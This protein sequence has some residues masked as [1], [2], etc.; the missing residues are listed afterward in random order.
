MTTETRRR[1]GERLVSNR[2]Y[3]TLSVDLEEAR[4]K[5]MDD[6]RGAAPPKPPF[7]RAGG[8]LETLAAH[9][10]ADSASPARTDAPSLCRPPDRNGW[11]TSRRPADRSGAAWSKPVARSVRLPGGMP[12]RLGPIIQHHAA[13]DACWGLSAAASVILAPTA[14]AEVCPASLGF[15]DSPRPTP[16]FAR[17]SRAVRRTSL[18]FCVRSPSLYATFFVRSLGEPFPESDVSGRDCPSTPGPRMQLAVRLRPRGGTA[19]R[20]GPTGVPGNRG[21]DGRWPR[22][23][24]C[25]PR[26]W[27]G[28]CWTSAP[29]RVGWWS[30]TGDRM[31]PSGD[32]SSGNGQAAASAD[33]RFGRESWEPREAPKPSGIGFAS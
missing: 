7:P 20:S 3:G 12:Q 29:G 19:F 32:A 23:R 27:R 28:C 8:A 15:R 14:P 6:S 18:P 5:A 21:R 24:R 1:S 10:A 25:R 22:G 30:H 2:P 4:R 11:Q 17:R 26:C 13:L 33:G 16:R 9:G 31:K